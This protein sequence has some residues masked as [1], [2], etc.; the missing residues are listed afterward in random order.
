[1]DR[2]D[3]RDEVRKRLMVPRVRSSSVE[4][5][6]VGAEEADEGRFPKGRRNQRLG[7]STDDSVGNDVVDTFGDEMGVTGE[8]GVDDD[9]T[10]SWG[11]WGSS[12]AEAGIVS[13][14]SPSSVGGRGSSAPSSV[15][16]TDLRGSGRGANLIFLLGVERGNRL[17]ELA[18]VG[19]SSSELEE[20][21]K[22]EVGVDIGEGE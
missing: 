9:C 2:R 4:M 11:V 8:E 18:G 14:S 10:E 6:K 12:E 13:G 20:L 19:F 1:M 7:L 21:Q 15:T 22:V 3:S 5:L 17:D 16:S